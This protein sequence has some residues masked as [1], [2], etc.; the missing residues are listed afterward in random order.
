MYL[1]SGNVRK[2]FVVASRSLGRTPLTTPSKN[3]VASVV[4]FSNCRMLV[5]D[6]SF[7]PP[8]LLQDSRAFSSVLLEL[9]D[10]VDLRVVDLR[11]R[12]KALRRF[13]SISRKNSVDHSFEELCS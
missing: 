7:L 9:L 2:Y 3:Y 12:R 4:A 6:L 1:I 11:E 10:E 5:E 8:K 13:K